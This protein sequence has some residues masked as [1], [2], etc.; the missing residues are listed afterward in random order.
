VV[1]ES[2]AAAKN[3]QSQANDLRDVTSRFKLPNAALAF[4]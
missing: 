2:A 4:A 3:L 1:E